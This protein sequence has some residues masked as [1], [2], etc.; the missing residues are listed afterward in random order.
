MSDTDLYID[1]APIRM[2][3]G[4]AQGPAGQ[5]LT[6]EINHLSLDP[7]PTGVPT[8]EGTVSWNSDDHTLN[9]QTDIAGVVQQV[10]QEVHIRVRNTTGSTIQNGSVVY[11]SGAS[12]QRPLVA[13]AD[14]DN[15]THVL[16]TIGV[17]TADID[18]NAFGYVTTMGLVRGVNTNGMTEGN[19]IYLST[20]AGAFTQSVPTGNKVRV[21]WCI[22]AGNNGTILVHVDKQSIKSADVVDATTDG[23]TNPSKAL[24]TTAG[25]ALTIKTLTLGNATGEDGTVA[26]FGS[27]G[28]QAAVDNSN[29]SDAVVKAPLV[30]GT[31][32]VTA[33]TDGVPDAIIPANGATTRTNLG[34]GTS[35]S[36]SFANVTATT[37]ATSSY[38]KEGVTALGTVVASATITITGGSHVTATLTA[39]TA[40]TFT[41]PTPAAGLSFILYLKQAAVTGNGSATF[42]GV[43]WSGGTAP[44]ITTTAGRMDIL[45]FTAGPDAAGTGYKWYGSV[46][47]NVTPS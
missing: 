46:L 21:G 22:I 42:T 34:L 4:G 24:K 6:G 31:L 2:E 37:L 29:N 19:A 17:A 9:L 26:I 12:G 1:A 35:D 15:D 25:S 10:G 30:S 8:T 18:H 39:S 27:L 45:S 43:I 11:L 5:G 23:V 40:C 33:R 41:M 3:V 28:N 16:S 36:P 47:Q 32:A 38:F 7:T 13:L 44:T 14:A 20:T